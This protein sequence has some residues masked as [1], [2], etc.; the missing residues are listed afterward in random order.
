MVVS[1][2]LLSPLVGVHPTRM[3]WANVGGLAGTAVFSLIAAMTTSDRDTLIGANL[4]GSLV[5]LGVGAYVGS[6]I[7][8]DPTP[9]R[10]KHKTAAF[11]R[12]LEWQPRL[13]FQP[14]MVETAPGKMSSEGMLLNLALRQP[15]R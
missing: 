8:V 2:L 5:G 9:A 14:W 1:G 3:G 11:D 10:L 6:R 7:K 15:T 13:S 12:F 4:A